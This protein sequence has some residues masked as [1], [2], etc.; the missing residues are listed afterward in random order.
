[1]EVKRTSAEILDWYNIGREQAAE[2]ERAKVVAA[3]K[4]SPEWGGYDF[5]PGLALAVEIIEALAHLSAP[6]PPASR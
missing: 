6:N 5:G 2:A 4:A 3:L 1:M